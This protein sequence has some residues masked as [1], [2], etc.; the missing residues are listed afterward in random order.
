M[1]KFHILVEQFSIDAIKEWVSKNYQNFEQYLNS[2]V[3]S[4]SIQNSYGQIEEFFPPEFEWTPLHIAV[5]RGDPEVVEMLLKYGANVNA[6]T[7]VTKVTPLMLSC[8]YINDEIVALLLELH[9]VNLITALFSICQIYSKL[10][11][12][13]EKND[14]KKIIKLLL[15]NKADANEVDYD[16]GQT[17]WIIIAKYVDIELLSLFLSHGADPNGRCKRSK[18][19]IMDMIGDHT[20]YKSNQQKLELS[21]KLLLLSQY[22]AD[23]NVTSTYGNIFHRSILCDMPIDFLKWLYF[24]KK[25]DIFQ[26]TGTFSFSIHKHCVLEI[27]GAN[28][29]HI[30]SL[31]GKDDVIDF[32]L[33]QGLSI[34]SQV[35][36]FNEK[37]TPIQCACKC[38]HFSTYINLLNAGA[39]FEE[40]LLHI[41]VGEAHTEI[42]KDL[43]KRGE[44]VNKSIKCWFGQ[45]DNFEKL[46]G[47]VYEGSSLFPAILR[48]SVEMTRI[49]LN[50]GVDVNTCGRIESGIIGAHSLG[51]YQ[52]RLGK[53]DTVYP[54]QIA[55]YRGVPE[56]VR[57]LVGHG[58]D[59]TVKTILPWI[60]QLSQEPV[61]S[62]E[63]SRFCLESKSVKSPTDTNWV[64]CTNYIKYPTEVD[65]KKRPSVL[66]DLFSVFEVESESLSESGESSS[67]DCN[68]S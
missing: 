46:I 52:L 66:G 6:C 11:D 30:A 68:I 54:I 4:K 59:V 13:N 47:C 10:T 32:L 22:G 64:L 16:T 48:G 34:D 41:V 50:S 56:I 8:E 1:N 55:A 61:D 23:M 37:W 19:Y 12:D 65:D 49:L 17:P 29:L 31:L 3:E 20:L 26:C 51:E 44:N 14:A 21:D 24:D 9:P 36:I 27:N 39:L 35:L 40:N 63:I 45:K 28:T 2:T 58:A 15:E 5:K 53:W 67:S 60:R 7:A 57:L 62:L 33:D 25:V 18:R 42:V 43:L 38:G